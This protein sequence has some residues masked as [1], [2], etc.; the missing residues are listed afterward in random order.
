MFSLRSDLS[1]QSPSVE[2][3]EEDPYQFFAPVDANLSAF[4]IHLL[5]RFRC[6]NVAPLYPSPAHSGLV[7]PLALK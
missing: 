7:S 2:S 3:S 1:R 5:L 6:T 4:M